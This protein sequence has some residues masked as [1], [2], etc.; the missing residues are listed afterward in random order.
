MGFLYNFKHEYF[1]IYC[2]NSVYLFIICLI[3]KFAES[4]YMNELTN[5]DTEIQLPKEVNPRSYFVGCQWYEEWAT[6][7]ITSRNFQTTW[8]LS[9]TYQ[10]NKTIFLNN[11]H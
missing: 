11:H 3:N 10:S 4:L 8:Y 5:K 1:I 2:L 6:V 7:V 9:C